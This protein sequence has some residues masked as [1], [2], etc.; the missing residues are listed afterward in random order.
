MRRGGE[1]EIVCITAVPHVHI[2]GIVWSNSPAQKIERTAAFAARPSLYFVLFHFIC[3][4]LTENHVEIP[5]LTD[6]LCNFNPGYFPLESTPRNNIFRLSRIYHGPQNRIVPPLPLWVW[7]YQIAI[8][9]C[10]CTAKGKKRRYFLVLLKKGGYR[11]EYCL[12]L[13]K[14]IPLRRRHIQARAFTPLTGKAELQLTSRKTTKVCTP[15]RRNN[16]FI[17]QPVPLLHC[18]LQCINTFERPFVHVYCT[19]VQSPYT[20]FFV[21]FQ[22]IREGPYFFPRGYLFR[23][24]GLLKK[25]KRLRIDGKLYIG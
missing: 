22:K 12:L 11:R 23:H 19:Y 5:Y 13:T 7:I 9:D 20:V 8:L 3:T 25:E 10:C 14:P 1:W 24:G 6:P 17:C 15:G 18:Y 21:Y 16:F 4:L 2:Q